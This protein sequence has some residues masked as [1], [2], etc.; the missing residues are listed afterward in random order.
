[1]LVQV[2]VGR[3]CFFPKSRWVS[4]AQMDLRNVGLDVSGVPVL[5]RIGAL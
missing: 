2:H 1:M 5:R 4:G 3:T